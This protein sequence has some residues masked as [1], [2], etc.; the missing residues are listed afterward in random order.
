MKMY[1]M[2]ELIVLLF[3]LEAAIG[4]AMAA[5]LVLSRWIWLGPL[6][7]RVTVLGLGAP[8]NN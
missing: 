4:V 8:G 3:A 2:N 6:V 1:V 7:L 5:V